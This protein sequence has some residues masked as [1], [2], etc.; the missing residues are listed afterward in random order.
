MY[1]LQELRSLTRLIDLVDRRCEKGEEHAPEELVFLEELVRIESLDVPQLAKLH[2]FRNDWGIRSDPFRG[3]LDVVGDSVDE[4]RDVVE[5]LVTG[6]DSVAFD[7]DP[8]GDALEPA[9][10]ELRTRRSKP[11]S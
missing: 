2:G 3:V 6:E 8:S 10:R 7:R 1:A 4:E 5:Q 11:S 9:R